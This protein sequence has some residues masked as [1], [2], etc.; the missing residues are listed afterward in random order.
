MCSYTK[1]VRFVRRHHLRFMQWWPRPRPAGWLWRGR[2][3]QFAAVAR[4]TTCRHRSQTSALFPKG[5]I[6]SV[7]LTRRRRDRSRQ[8]ISGS[9]LI[10]M[11][12]L[13]SKASVVLL[14]FASP[15]LSEQST[16]VVH[17][18]GLSDHPVAGVR[19]RAGDSSISPPSAQGGSN[20]PRCPNQAGRRRHLGDRLRSER[21]RDDLA[22]GQVGPLASV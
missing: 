13:H 12:V 7:K 15:L 9:Y 3:E 20:P 5:R 18:K 21:S 8:S 17:V 14:L 10:P 11:A 2:L 6:F 16:L 19:F 1:V 4:R 22:L